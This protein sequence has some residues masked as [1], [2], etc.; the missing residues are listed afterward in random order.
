[1]PVGA[2]RHR[3]TF[4][5]VTSEPDGHGGTIDVWIDLAPP[6]WDVSITPATVRDLEREAASTIV[7]SATHVIVGRYRGDV[8]IECRMLFEGREFRIT[9]VKNAD[10]RGIE[11]FLFA[12]ETI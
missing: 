6:T 11:M 2:L 1:M 5:T 4:Q 8:T 3:V 7:A 12:K 9:G 10:E